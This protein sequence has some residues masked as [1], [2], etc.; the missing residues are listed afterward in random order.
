MTLDIIF[1]H[2]YQTV[3]GKE[4]RNIFDI[5]HICILFFNMKIRFN[6]FMMYLQTGVER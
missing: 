6:T 5:I 1:H 2:E 4:E 3:S